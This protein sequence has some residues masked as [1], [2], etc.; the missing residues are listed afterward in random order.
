MRVIIRQKLVQELHHEHTG[1][2]RMKSVARNYLR[3]PG[4]DKDTE[5]VAKACE[6]F[7]SLRNDPVPAPLTPYTFPTHVWERVTLIYSVY[8]VKTT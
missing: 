5:A 3:Y 2:V 6:M 1:I 7:S 4:L 8:K